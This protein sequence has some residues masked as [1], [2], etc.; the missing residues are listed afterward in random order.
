MRFLTDRRAPAHVDGGPWAAGGGQR[1][2]DHS[3]STVGVGPVWR[4]KVSDARPDQT[5]GR[6]NL[7][8]TTLTLPPARPCCAVKGKASDMRP[9]NA[10]EY[11]AALKRLGLSQRA[12]GPWLGVSSRQAQ[13]FAS[14]ERAVPES[15][16]ML[17]R[18]VLRLGLPVDE[19][20]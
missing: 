1:I 18:L 15:I 7:A 16:A 17:I 6:G 13:R 11:R 20:R 2:V 8:E 5:R 9:M 10:V 4:A 14:A 12:A 3:G 19:V